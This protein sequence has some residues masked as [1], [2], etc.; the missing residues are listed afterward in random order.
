MTESGAELVAAATGLT[1]WKILMGKAVVLSEKGH[2][3][4]SV[5]NLEALSFPYTDESGCF[6]RNFA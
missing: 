2:V 5:P 1:N 3:M 6:C 4:E